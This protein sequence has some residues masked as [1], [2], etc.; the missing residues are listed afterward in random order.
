[1]SDALIPAP[2]RRTEGDGACGVG[3]PWHIVSTEPSVRALARTLHTLFTPH[4]PGL[5]VRD[6]SGQ[7]GP[8][9]SSAREVR[10]VLGDVPLQPS[11]LGVPPAGEPTADECGRLTVDESGVT[12]R[13]RTRVGVFRTAVSALRLISDSDELPHQ[14]IDDGPRFAWRGLL[15]DVA[16]NFFPSGEVRQIIDLAALYKLNVLH[17]H[18]TDN[19]GW[20]LEIPGRPGLTTGFRAAEDTGAAGRRGFYSVGEFRQLQEYAAERFVTVVPEIDLP[21]HCAAAVRGCPE[22]ETMPRPAWL[23]PSV[24]YAPPLNPAGPGVRRFVEDV[25]TEVARQTT[26]PYV[27]IGGDEALGIDPQN[28]G[29]AVRRAREVVRAAGK[30]PLGWQES[31][32]AGVEPDGIAQFWVDVPMM[33]LPENE[34]DLRER[35]ELLESGFTLGFGEKL[36]R[37]FAPSDDDVR[38]IVEGGG[39][40]LM[41]PQSHLYL[42][43]PYDA[44]VTPPEQAEVARGLAF[45]YRPRTVEYMAGWDPTAHGVPEERMAGVEA[46]VFCESVRDVE[47]LTMLLLPR[48]AAVAETAWSPAPPT[49]AEY[50][51][52]LARQAPLWRRRGLNYLASTEVPWR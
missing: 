33:D 38:R 31:T 34:A 21:G 11:A 40:V 3:G 41:S 4:L 47:G 9:A 50:R 30:Q 36:R 46:T 42:D 17:L 37:F 35:P 49:W 45:A 5:E 48:L 24:S 8:A 43:R 25:L 15:L 27:H 20:C 16:R 18:L 13:A 2:V 29:A 22:I 51:E 26:G 12:C 10:L 44:A 23:D 7:L 1:M 39:L 32:R 52:R 14:C 28:F 19:E 6:D